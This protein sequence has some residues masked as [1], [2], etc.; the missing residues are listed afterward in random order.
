MGRKWKSTA[1]GKTPTSEGRPCRKSVAAPSPVAAEAPEPAA[2]FNAMEPHHQRKGGPGPLKQARSAGAVSLAKEKVV[3]LDFDVS[4]RVL[5]CDMCHGLLKAPIFQ[6][7][8]LR[9]VACRSCSECHG[10][11]CRPCAD[12]ATT[13]V[14]VQSSY[15]D[16]LFGHIKL[17]EAWPYKKYGCTSSIPVGEGDPAA[18]WELESCW[19]RPCPFKG[20]PAD[21]VRHLTGRHALAAHKFTYGQ[22]Y[23]YDSDEMDSSL[24]YADE[25]GSWTGCE[26]LLVGEDGGVFHLM[27]DLTADFEQFPFPFVALLCVRNSA[28]AAAAAGPVYS[29][30]VAAV[31][32]PPAERR[33]LKPEIKEVVV[34]P[35]WKMKRDCFR[36]FPAML[37]EGKSVLV[38]ICI[39]KAE[40]SSG[41]C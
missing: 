39:S 17:K 11:K 15:L 12:L 31:D 10:G 9:H 16:T 14:Y 4:M 26:E 8:L 20:S 21:L 30:S 18:A 5:N 23:I 32:A 13:A 25:M 27:A 22:D 1:H 41:S 36:L 7:S 3:K 28:A 38:R 19:F 40:S 34:G 35:D 33:K 37:R 6:C 24:V 2:A 29:Y